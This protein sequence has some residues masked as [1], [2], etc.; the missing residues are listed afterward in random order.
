MADYQRFGIEVVAGATAYLIVLLV[1]HI[2][3]LRGFIHFYQRSRFQQQGGGR[4][5]YRLPGDAGRQR[6]SADARRAASSL[7]DRDGHES[8]GKSYGLPIVPGRAP[9]KRGFGRDS[10]RATCHGILWCN[11]RRSLVTAVFWPDIV[12]GFH[13]K[14]I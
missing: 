7:P 1:L 10:K 3:R 14:F 12:C 2:D 9:G 5:M 11:D 6:T 13:S 4:L 8:F